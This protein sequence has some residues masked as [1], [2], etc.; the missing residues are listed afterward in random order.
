M[1]IVV[2]AGGFSPERDVSLSSGSQIANALMEKGHRVLLADLYIGMAEDSFSEAY[3][4]H[5][6]T[7]YT[8]DV[9]EKEPDL[10]ALRQEQGGRKELVGPNVIKLCRSADFTFLALHGG[11]G[12]NGKLQA[13]LDIYDIRYSGSDYKSSMLAMDKVLS[14]QLMR[15]FEVKTPD[16]IVLREGEEIK[17]MLPSVVKPIDAG[18]SIGVQIVETEDSFV[19]AVGEAQKYSKSVLAEELIQGR[20]FSVGILGDKAL[21]VIE[22]IPKSGFYDYASKYQAEATVEVT[23]A[24]IPKNLAE[25]MQKTAL[26]V[27][28]ILGLSVYSRVDFIV[29]NEKE[30]F[31]IEA[32]NL[33]GMTPTSLVPQ[34]AR[35]TGISYEALCGKIIDLSMQ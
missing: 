26:K 9:P 14:K 24:E 35:A 19:E 18:S 16:W 34:E 27:H 2:L 33:P 7:C 20:E 21:P 15:H 12:E 11:I 3:E 25:E 5:K 28:K 8:Y 13:L 17:K 10:E 22:I 31:C 30:I 32:N 1:D 4:K 6:S 23:P 29:R